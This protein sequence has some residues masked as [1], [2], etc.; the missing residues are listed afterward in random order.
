[1]R[2]LLCFKSPLPKKWHSLTCAG[3]L[4][5]FSAIALASPGDAVAANNVAICH[6]YSGNLMSAVQVGTHHC[7][8]S[9]A[10]GDPDVSIYH[11]QMHICL[12]HV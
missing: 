11:R 10:P 6:M 3:A 9:S 4:T 8:P 7:K 5:E 2:R 1:M 12:E